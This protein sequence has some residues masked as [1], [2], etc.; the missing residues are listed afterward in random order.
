L[1]ISKLNTDGMSHP[2]GSSYKE[3]RVGDVVTPLTGAYLN[4]KGSS[5]LNGTTY[6]YRRLRHSY[7]SN[8]NVLGIMPFLVTVNGEIILCVIT[9]RLATSITPFVADGSNYVSCDFF[10]LT[11]KPLIKGV[12]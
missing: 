9:I 8:G 10:S 5:L 7:T 1:L 3:L 11:S 6:I 12:N 4:K 2:S